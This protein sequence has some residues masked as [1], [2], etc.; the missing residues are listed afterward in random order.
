MVQRFDPGCCCG[1]KVCSECCTDGLPNSLDITM[2]SGW[3]EPTVDAGKCGVSDPHADCCNAELSGQTF[4]LSVGPFYLC[5]AAPEQAACIYSYLDNTWC[6]VDDTTVC[7]PFP[8]VATDAYMSFQA[9]FS[10][11]TSAPNKGKCCIKVVLDICAYCLWPERCAWTRYRWA[12]SYFEPM[13]CAGFSKS[14]AWVSMVNYDNADPE[15]M[16]VPP[17]QAITVE[18]GG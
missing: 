3:V 9:Y 8:G 4:N 18:D 6:P 5:A 12:T 1:C 15:G 11:A 17:L 13:T 2:A 10:C 7:D 14:A 16:C